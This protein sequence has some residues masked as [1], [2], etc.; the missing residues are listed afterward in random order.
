MSRGVGQPSKPHVSSHTSV[1]QTARIHIAKRARRIPRRRVV[2]APGKPR[3][4][5]FI[6]ENSW[7]KCI[8]QSSFRSL[9]PPSPAKAAQPIPPPRRA[10]ITLIR[11][12][13]RRRMSVHQTPRRAS[14]VQPPLRPAPQQVPPRLYPQQ[15]PELQRAPV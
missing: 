10:P 14:R 6:S 13:R 1:K 9:S 12:P 4:L 3:L 11:P 8:V 5:A 7:E 15:T 2:N